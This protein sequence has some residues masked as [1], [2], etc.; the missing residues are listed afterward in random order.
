MSGI[1]FIDTAPMHETSLN[2][3]KKIDANK[4][5]FMQKQL[6][7]W[8]E[9]TGHSTIASLQYTC[10]H[11]SNLFKVPRF[12]PNKNIFCWCCKLIILLKGGL[13]M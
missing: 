9:R 11:E 13:E 10:I 5:K 6:R 7:I 1:E 2:A 12:G 4:A 8:T 3:L